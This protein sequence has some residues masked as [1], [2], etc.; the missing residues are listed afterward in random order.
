MC[1][2]EHKGKPDKERILGLAGLATRA[3]KVIF[4][5][6][7]TCDAMRAGKKIYLVLEACDTAEN[8]HKRITDRCT[9]YHVPHRRIDVA[10][11]D[12]AH[13]LGKSGDL[14]VVGITDRGLA[15]AIQGLLPAE[16]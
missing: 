2:S 9:Y 12:L 3:G 5:T 10:T 14:A 15:E 8:T 13:A 16:Q 7:M 4:G 6:P 1:N 11:G